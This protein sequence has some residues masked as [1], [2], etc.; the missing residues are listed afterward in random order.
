VVVKKVWLT[1]DQ[2][3]EQIHLIVEWLDSAGLSIPR[4]SELDGY[5]RYQYIDDNMVWYFD[6]DLLAIEFKLRFG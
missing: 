4:V 2:A 3:E 1:L 5:V 6:D